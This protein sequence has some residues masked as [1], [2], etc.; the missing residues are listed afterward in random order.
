ME[1]HI[2]TAFARSSVVKIVCSSFDGI[3]WGGVLEY[4]SNLVT[5]ARLTKSI[6]LDGFVV[7]RTRDV[8]SVEFDIEFEKFVQL[9]FRL[10]LIAPLFVR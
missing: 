2:A 9:A 5:I 8:S 1:T 6:S 4:N 3:I 7:V 10:K